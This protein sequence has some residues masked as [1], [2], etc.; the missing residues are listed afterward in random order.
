MDFHDTYTELYK[1][2]QMKYQWQMMNIDEYISI[3]IHTYIAMYMCMYV[4]IYMYVNI[5]EYW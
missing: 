2:G 5:E 1:Y 4:Y 3:Y